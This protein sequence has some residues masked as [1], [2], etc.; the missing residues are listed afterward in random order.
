MFPRD[1]A[2]VSGVPDVAIAA[3]G[4]SWAYTFLRRLS[5]LNVVSG[6]R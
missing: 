6:I 5:D 4:Q 2:G 1:P 3:D